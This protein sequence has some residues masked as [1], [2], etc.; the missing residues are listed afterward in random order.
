MVVMNKVLCASSWWVCLLVALLMM[1]ACSMPKDTGEERTPRR[2]RTQRAETPRVDLNLQAPVDAVQTIQLYAEEE[3]QLPVVSMRGGRKLTLEFD[4]M[5][6]NGRP[7]SAYFYHAN[8]EWERDL[9]ASEYLTSFH[10]DDL[11]DYQISRNTQVNYSHYTYTFPNNSIGFRI[12]GNFI[13][14]ITEQGREDEVLFERPFFVAEN[15]ATLQ[16]GI[17]NVM[18]GGQGYPS[19]QPILSFTPP[20]SLIGNI[21][22][23][24]VCFVQNGQLERSRCSSNP[25]L[26]QQPDLLF[27][28]QPENAF[29]PQEGD[30]YLDLSNLTIGGRVERTDLSVTPYLIT[31]E[32]DYARFP[33]S[34]I[35][36]LLNGQPVISDADRFVGDADTQGEYARVLFRYVPPD[37]APLPGGVFIAGS[38][39]GWDFDL[40][41]Q[42]TWEADLGRYEGELLIKQ[43]KYEYRYTS[44]DPRVRRQLRARLPRPDNLYTALVYFSDVTLNTD[45]LLA[46]QNILSR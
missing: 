15:A 4:L 45:R 26:T 30:Y 39:N 16:F 44:P 25:S 11:F 40:A 22:D 27:Y 31:L 1:A 18:V 43:G 35:E 28:L 46:Y 2:V 38:F 3:D 14:R 37:E 42:L 12:S 33:S 32:P 8:R 13:V 41:N 23:Y 19:A 10:R 21:F 5:D 34:G 29:E 24:N 20:S 36:P 17:E 7:L 9:N 6:S